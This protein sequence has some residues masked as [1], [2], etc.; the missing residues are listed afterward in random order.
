MR[1][2]IREAQSFYGDVLR[3]DHRLE[4]EELFM[5][6]R[7]ES[8]ID[9]WARALVAVMAYSKYGLGWKRL[10]KGLVMF[11]RDKFTDDALKNAVLHRFYILR[12]EM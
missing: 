10:F 4:I 9:Y 6:F 7:V 2:L 12:K 3:S 1:E 5:S 8:S 11:G